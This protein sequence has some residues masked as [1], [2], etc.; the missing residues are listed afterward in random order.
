MAA[1]TPTAR[2][3][4][5]GYKVPDGFKTLVTLANKPAISFWEKTPKPP[6]MDGGEPVNTTTM[7]NTAYRTFAPKHLVT[8]TA[9]TF[10][11]AYDPDVY[12]DIL[13][14]IN[15]VQVITVRFP[16][17]STLCFWGFLQKFEPGDNNEGEM[18]LATVT[19]MPTNQDLQ[20][21]EQ[22]PVLTQAPG[23]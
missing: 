21:N 9:V 19:I 10:Q 13:V 4:P 8:L 22:A 16:D 3:T 5:T 15:A 14:Q 20:T 17:T 6:G 11:A 23:T 18:P 7:H 12:A 2:Q 1:P